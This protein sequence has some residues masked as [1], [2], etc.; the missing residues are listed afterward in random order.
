MNF[1]GSTQLDECGYED[2]YRISKLACAVILLAAKDLQL[3]TDITQ[4]MKEWEK[5]RRKINYAHK[6][7]A[8]RWFKGVE[9][10]SPFSLEW[11]CDCINRVLYS[12]GEIEFLLTP[13]LLRKAAFSEPEKIIKALE[14]KNQIFNSSFM[15]SEQAYFSTQIN[16]AVLEVI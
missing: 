13:A 10:Y 4:E 7:L 6:G 8:L 15:R 16:P 12:L 5:I 1:F 11:C 14:S 2:I 9:K 3:P